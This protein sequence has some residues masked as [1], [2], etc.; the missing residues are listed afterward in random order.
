MLIQTQLVL[1]TSWETCSLRDDS[2]QLFR[3]DATAEVE[4]NVYVESQVITFPDEA[5]T[6]TLPGVLV[7][8]ASVFIDHVPRDLEG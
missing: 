5:D 6:A 4:G 2:M 3:F 8:F 7:S 1:V